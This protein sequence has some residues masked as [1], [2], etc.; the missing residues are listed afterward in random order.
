MTELYEWLRSDAG[1]VLGQ[2]IIYANIL[3]GIW[4]YVMWFFN[5]KSYD[6][7]HESDYWMPLTVFSTVLVLVC[8]GAEAIKRLEYNYDGSHPFA[9]IYVTVFGIA[10]IMLGFVLLTQKG[11]KVRASIRRRNSTP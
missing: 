4:L 11:A 9:A 1:W 6:V 10:I 7:F 3:H 8:S 5:R 2:C